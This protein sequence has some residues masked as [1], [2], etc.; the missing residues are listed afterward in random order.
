MQY[1]FDHKGQRYL[2][3]IGGICTISVG[4][5]HPRIVEAIQKQA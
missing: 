1:L 4:H 2:D 3:L 5:S